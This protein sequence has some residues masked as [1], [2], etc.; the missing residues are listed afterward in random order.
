MAERVVV[1]AHQNWGP[2]NAPSRAGQID[3]FGGFCPPFS[4][5]S[6]EFRG[7][8]GGPGQNTD[9]EVQHKVKGQGGVAESCHFSPAF[10]A[11]ELL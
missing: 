5:D 11:P 7:G 1:T 10:S 6:S 2:F 9:N 4:A 3:P 8:R